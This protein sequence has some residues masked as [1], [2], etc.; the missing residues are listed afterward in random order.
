MPETTISTKQ[1]RDSAIT[2]AK[3]AAGAAIASS[4]LADG[5]NF[6]KKDGSVAF[7][8]NQS[9]GN[10]KLTSLSNGTVSTD[11]INLGQLDAAIAALS[12]AYK[13]RTV[14]VV[15]TANV[16]ISSAPSSVDSVTLSTGDRVLLTAQSTASQNG[17]YDFNGAAAAM[18]RSTDSDAWNEII[19]S[20]VAVVEGTAKDNSR[21]FCTANTGGTLGSTSITY[22]EDQSAGLSS[23]NFVNDE[24]PSGSI[25]GSN[26]SFTLANTPTSGTLDLF[27]NGIRLKGGS[28]DYAI[29]GNTITMTTAPVTGDTLYANYRK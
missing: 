24:T 2:D 19:G 3:V 21:W 13:Y 25:N 17:I 9:M 4:K 1:I 15:A 20:L 23:S 16:N 14:R 28:N 18:T 6:T 7:T 8:G 22:T 26:T 5:A 29:S 27:M 12:T 11:A 10:N